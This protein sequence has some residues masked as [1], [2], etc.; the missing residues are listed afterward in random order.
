MSFNIKQGDVIPT[1]QMTGRGSYYDFTK[2]VVTSDS[3]VGASLSSTFGINNKRMDV[4]NGG[5][6]TITI[7]SQ[8]GSNFYLHGT[9]QVPSITISAGE[10]AQFSRNGS[11]DDM[12]AVQ[13]ISAQSTTPQVPSDADPLMDGESSPGTS[14]AYSRGDHI[15]PSDTA[16]EDHSNK[17]ASPD[18]D[19]DTDFPTAKAA[20]TRAATYQVKLTDP[21]TGSQVKAVLSGNGTGLALNSGTGVLTINGTTYIRNKSECYFSG[22]NLT[23]PTTSTNLIN[24][25]K[26]LPHTGNL[27]PFFNTT[28]NKLNVFNQNQSVSFKINVIGS[29]SGASTNR[30]MTIDFPQ[31]NGNS[32]TKT[33]DAS[34]TT[35]QVS[36]ST[37]FSVDLGGNMVTNPT[38]ITIAA[39]GAVFTATAILLI[40]EQI[41]PVTQ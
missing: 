26:A 16:K 18:W 10:L 25:I 19:S 29:W 6:N 3:P 36:M 30:S 2:V 1:A 15:H 38:D 31:T 28:T 12:V 20:D 4:L 7:T 11:F 41:V 17:K 40:A 9:G 14:T 5:I 37:F 35:D 13:K 8:D 39:N 33:R 32:L 23:I 21:A 34:V 27:S 24:L 22:L